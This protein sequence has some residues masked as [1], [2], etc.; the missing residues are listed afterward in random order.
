MAVRKDFDYSGAI[1]E[2]EEILAELQQP[3]TPLDVAIQLHEKG[4]KLIVKIE[5]FLKTAENEVK[6]HLAKD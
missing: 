4:Q 2:L 6:K 1:R 3:D 5:T